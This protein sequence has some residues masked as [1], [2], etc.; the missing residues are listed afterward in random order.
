MKN[1]ANFTLISTFVLVSFLLL[2]SAFASAADFEEG[3]HY[4]ELSTPINDNL[5]STKE[6]RE[7][8]SFYCPACYRHEPIIDAL[9]AQLPDNIALIKNPIDGMPGRDI[10]IE[11][12]LAKALLTARLLR[13]E[14]KIIDAIFK[15]IYVNKAT[16]TKEKDIKNIFLLHGIEERRFDKIFNSFSVKTGVNKMKNNTEILRNQGISSVPTII[17]NGKFKVETGEIKSKQQYIDLVLYLL[18]L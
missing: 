11:Q 18:T 3:R 1:N 7:F 5:N 6:V 16:F 10:A 9:K 13:V 15:Y 2:S 8:F 4:I 17:V 12:A 14:D